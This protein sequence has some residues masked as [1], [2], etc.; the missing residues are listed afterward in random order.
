MLCVSTNLMKPHFYLKGIIMKQNIKYLKLSFVMLLVFVCSICLFTGCTNGSVTTDNLATDKV[1]SS[2][3]NQDKS[4]NCYYIDV[5]IYSDKD[6]TINS[7]DF[8]YTQDGKTK[9]SLGFILEIN[10]ST[11]I[12][13]GKTESV[14]VVSR[15]GSEFDCE[16]QYISTA[17]LIVEDET[18]ISSVYYKGKAITKTSLFK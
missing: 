5:K 16:K 11:I 3:L 1:I 6:I 14:T 18:A 4:A 13:N 8:T 12:V 9:T 17:K 10:R 15:V 7:A 2:Y